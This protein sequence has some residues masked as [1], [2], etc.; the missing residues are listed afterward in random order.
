MSDVVRIKLYVGPSA[1]DTIEVDK[2]YW[3]E[4]SEEERGKFMYSAAVDFRNNVIECS[5]WVLDEGDE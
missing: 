4:M 1:E 3:D 5:A 2:E